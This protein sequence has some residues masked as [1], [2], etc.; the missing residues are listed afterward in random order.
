M[1]RHHLASAP[2][3]AAQRSP[4]PTVG[5]KA[6]GPSAPK[7]YPHSKPPT[8]SVAIWVLTPVMCSNQHQA[9]GVQQ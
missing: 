2:R 8:R 4:C 1:L 5:E 9:A 7:N 6:L 3:G